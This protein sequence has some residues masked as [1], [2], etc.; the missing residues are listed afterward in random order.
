MFVYRHPAILFL[1]LNVF[2]CLRKMSTG[3]ETIL[4][5]G[6]QEWKAE[7][8]GQLRVRCASGER[9]FDGKSG[10][11]EMRRARITLEYPVNKIYMGS[12]V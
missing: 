1:K 11:K 6:T 2:D 10:I 12:D 5:G 7:A 9:S 3:R 4:K 8:R